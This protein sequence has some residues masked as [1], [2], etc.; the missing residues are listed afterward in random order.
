MKAVRLI[1]LMPDELGASHAN[2]NIPFLV[3]AIEAASGMT[4]IHKSYGEQTTFSSVLGQVVDTANSRE[5]SKVQEDTL[6]V[7]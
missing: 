1:E 5:C 6:K 7:V 2:P 4:S 3:L